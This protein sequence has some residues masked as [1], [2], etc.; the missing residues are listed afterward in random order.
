MRNN[1]Y[2]NM[3]SFG[4]CWLPNSEKVKI[5]KRDDAKYPELE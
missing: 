5:R 2:G 4:Q 1:A 3:F